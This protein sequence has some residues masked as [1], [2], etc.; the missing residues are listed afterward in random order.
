MVC[1]YDLREPPFYCKMTASHLLYRDTQVSQFLPCDIKVQMLV[2]CLSEAKNSFH[3]VV[4]SL[5][6]CP[7]WT[8]WDMSSPFP[9]KLNSIWNL[10]CLRGTLARYQECK[11]SDKRM[12]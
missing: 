4:R 9:L 7:C 10:T 8:V 1:F 11:M 6:L 3:K 2:N 12:L 5:G